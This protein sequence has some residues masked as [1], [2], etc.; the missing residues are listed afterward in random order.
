MICHIS[1]VYQY[2]NQ[3]HTHIYSLNNPFYGHTFNAIHAAIFVPD[4]LKIDLQNAPAL[5]PWSS[6]IA[7]ESHTCA[8]GSC[9]DQIN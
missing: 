5:A 7:R 9:I 8:R 3:A 1:R 4:L 6:T 2:L